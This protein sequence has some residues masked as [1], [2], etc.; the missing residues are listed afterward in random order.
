M[1]LAKRSAAFA[2]VG[3][4]LLA[5]LGLVQTEPTRIPP[6][7]AGRYA[8]V[9][10]LPIRLVQRGSGPDVLLIHGSPGSVE[11]WDG[12][13]DGLAARYR[14]TAYDRPGHGYSGGADPPHTP[15]LN[16]M[17]ALGVIRALGLRDVVV[18]GHSYGGST[19][20]ALA[21]EHPSE[22]RAL[23]V[24]GSNAYAGVPVPWL[25]R[26]LAVPILG[27]GVAAA[28]APLVGASRVEAGLRASFG[29]NADA[30]PTGF[31]SRRV[32]IW[33]RPSVTT[34]LAQERAT[35]EGA[36]REMAD[37]YGSIRTP[38][39][40]VYGRQDRNY[41]DGVRLCR[42][43]PGARLLTLEDTGHYVQVARPEPLVAA[44]EQAAGAR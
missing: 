12:I 42:E 2:L 14:V 41:E 20:L 5:A 1:R 39:T 18:V 10:G 22:L 4:L 30:I 3:L 40:G 25:Y 17:V 19:G 16:A 27:R 24:V 21:L 37:R 38:V 6:G 36:L 44:I 8:T 13:L 28:V 31:V 43:I 7:A 32:P 23:V 34:T 9:E 15:Q 11:D 29:P 26:L 33:T 35:F